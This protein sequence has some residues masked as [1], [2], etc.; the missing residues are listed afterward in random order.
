MFGALLSSILLFA[1]ADAQPSTSELADQAQARLRAAGEKRRQHKLL[2]VKKRAELVDDYACARYDSGKLKYPLRCGYRSKRIG[3]Q[4]DNATPSSSV[5]ADLVAAAQQRIDA[6]ESL[7]AAA[8]LRGQGLPDANKA[9]EEAKVVEGERDTKVGDAKKAGEEAIGARTKADKAMAEA[10]EKNTPDLNKTAVTL[11]TEAKLAEQKATKANRDAEEKKDEAARKRR[12]ADQVA[13]AA[14]AATAANDALTAAKQAKVDAEN[15]IKADADR[16]A[17][18]QAAGKGDADKAAKDAAVAAAG[19]ATKA[20]NTAEAAIKAADDKIAAATAAAK[21]ADTSAVSGSADAAKPAA[22]KSDA[23]KELDKLKAGKLIRWGI[24]GGVAPAFY[25][26]L[27]YSKNAASVPGMGAL[28]YV[29]FHPGYWRSKP[30]T[31]IYC[32]NRWTGE[33]NE[34]AAASAADDLAVERAKLIVDRLLASDKANNLGPKEVT[35]IMC[36]EGPCGQDD[37]Q[38]AGLARRANTGGSDAEAARTAL[39]AVVIRT[40]FDWRSGIPARCGSRMVG[41]WFG[42]PLKYTATVPHVVKLADGKSEVRRDRLDVTPLFATGLGVSPNAYV[43]LLA[44]ISLGKVNL[45]PGKDKD[46]ELVVS[47]LFGIGGNLDLLGFL[48]K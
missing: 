14:K 36:A 22:E 21:L 38:V 18:D 34:A 8:K 13:A 19:T 16:V 2:K 37:H 31:N 4:L 6:A 46:D 12:V 47:F 33:A 3:Q 35:A 39:T 28:T 20:W 10:R 27:N 17:K 40:T 24:T 45:P 1:T 48:T 25:Q 15:A 11:E 44:G 29:M 43:S 42:Y 5:V 32:A 26:P 7:I 30:E 23:Q 41:M 9:E